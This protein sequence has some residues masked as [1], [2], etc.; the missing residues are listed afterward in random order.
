MLEILLYTGIVL[1]VTGKVQLNVYVYIK[2][3]FEQL[4]TVTHLP[5]RSSFIFLS[6]FGH[7]FFF[8]LVR[9]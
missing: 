9:V 2:P 1:N 8:S 5:L 7:F 3:L 6:N 4:M